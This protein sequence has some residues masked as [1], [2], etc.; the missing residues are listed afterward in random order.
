MK[1]GKK[2]NVA[3]FTFLSDRLANPKDDVIF[4]Q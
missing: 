3:K 2:I 4:T 1:L